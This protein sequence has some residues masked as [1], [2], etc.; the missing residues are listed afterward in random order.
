MVA[1]Y[2]HSVWTYVGRYQ[3][4][5]RWGLALCE[6][7]CAGPSRNM[8]LSPCVASSNLVVLCQT[9]RACDLL[10]KCAPRNPPFK[11]TQGHLY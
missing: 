9:L 5:R 3:N 10:G 7:G 2:Y 6:R 1:V 8:H 11:V 4:W